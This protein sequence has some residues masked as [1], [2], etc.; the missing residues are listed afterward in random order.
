M[1]NFPGGEDGKALEEFKHAVKEVELENRVVFTLK[2][3]QAGC[4]VRCRGTDGTKFSI[5]VSLAYLNSTSALFCLRLRA[6]EP[7]R[8]PARLFFYCCTFLLYTVELLLR[9]AS[10]RMKR[11]TTYTKTNSRQR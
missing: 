9:G 1:K 7:T 6:H 8:P 3:L 11:N 2:E 4:S 10:S 5:R